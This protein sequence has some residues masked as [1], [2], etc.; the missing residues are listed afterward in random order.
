MEGNA[1]IEAYDSRSDYPLRTYT[2]HIPY[3]PDLDAFV[4]NHHEVWNIH[5]VEPPCIPPSI[6]GG[7]YL[8]QERIVRGPGRLEL[9]QGVLEQQ[10]HVTGSRRAVRG[11]RALPGVPRGACRCCRHRPV[12][13]PATNSCSYSRRM[14]RQ[15]HLGDAEET[16]GELGAPLALR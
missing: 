13:A 3:I 16:A 1:I 2:C 4:W 7:S 10:R 11:Q 14:G 9:R 8:W 6:E 5:G 15:Q 12:P